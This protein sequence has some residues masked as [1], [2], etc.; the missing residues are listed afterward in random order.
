[1]ETVALVGPALVLGQHAPSYEL[2]IDPIAVAGDGVA[3]NGNPAGRPELDR[4]PAGLFRPAWSG[5]PIADDPAVKDLGAEDS[6][7][8]VPDVVVLDQAAGGAL[9]P[10]RGPVVGAHR[11]DVFEPEPGHRHPRGGDHQDGVVAPAHDYRAASAQD[12]NLPN[13]PNRAAFEVAAGGHHDGV[14]GTGSGHRL[15]QKP[16]RPPR[17]DRDDTEQSNQPD[18]RGPRRAR[19]HS[20]T[21]RVS[22]SITAPMATHPPSAGQEVA[23]KL[24]NCFGPI[25]GG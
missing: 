10:D 22:A 25:N 19:R 6:E 15:G 14:T 11:F 16:D 3:L 23:W 5:D 13:D 24:S 9:E 12:G 17:R 7:V 4:V 21:E 2:E 1:M 18:H 20:T 8:G